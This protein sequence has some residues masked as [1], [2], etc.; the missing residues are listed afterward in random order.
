MSK[1]I[2]YAHRGASGYRFENTMAAF[3]KAVQLGTDGIELDLQL[4][5]DGIPFV[6]HDADLYRLAGIKA[7]VSQLT[8]GELRKIRI[9]KKWRRMFFGSRVP[10]LIDVVLFCQVHDIALNAELKET[11]LADPESIHSI[12]ASLSVL[13]NVHISSFHY[14]LLKK[15]KLIDD[16]VETA[17]LVRKNSVDWDNL[18]SYS[19]ADGFHIHKRLMREPYVK[20]IVET[21]KPI[22]VYGVT[23]KEKFVQNPPPY[24]KGWI[25][26][27][28]DR[29]L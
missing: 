23:G 5:E 4:S 18:A 27:Y 10:T 24:I 17:L 14:E 15:V 19:A 8:S 13:N 2:V 16:R 12:L 1:P 29:L 28:P 9:G 6:I 20:K 22:R 26:D 21:T 11:I 25:T 3:K 7:S